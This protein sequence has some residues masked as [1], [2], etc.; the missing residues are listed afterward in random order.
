MFHR[1][2]IRW[3]LASLCAAGAFA[4][5]PAAT[6]AAGS[7]TLQWLA[8]AQR[9]A[10]LGHWRAPNELRFPLDRLFE[11]VGE[12][13]GSNEL[14]ARAAPPTTGQGVPV[15]KDVPVLSNLFRNGRAPE[16]R[17]VEAWLTTHLPRAIGGDVTVAF[18]ETR[19]R[20]YGAGGET[21]SVARELV[22]GAAEPLRAKAQRVLDEL[23]ALRG[24]QVMVELT[25]VTRPA[26]PDAR[27]L[28]KVEALE[29]RAWQLAL[30]GLREAA[31]SGASVNI[32]SS[33][34]VVT[35]QGQ[36]ASI[37]VGNDV[38]YVKGYAVEL[39]GEGSFVA[40]P[41]IGVAHEG[42][43]VEILPILF[44]AGDQVSLSL[45]VRLSNVTRPIATFEA[46]LGDG[47]LKAE[48]PEVATQSF[49]S[50]LVLAANGGGARIDGLVWTDPETRKPVRAEI[51]VAARVA[52]PPAPEAGAP[53]IF[54]PAGGSTENVVMLD[55]RDVDMLAGAKAGDAV[56][57]V[58]G[59]V[60]VGRWTVDHASGGFLVL[61]RIEGRAPVGAV[62]LRLAAK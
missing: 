18:E 38:S 33:P 1:R 2:L 5:E 8:L 19:T 51:Y 62:R 29:P 52:E 12:Q 13:R 9:N 26:P 53:K 15:L 35:G 30:A 58:D 16:L 4:Q 31:K 55:G 17:P 41:T 44:G 11:N 45:K 57:V 61:K 60:V 39:V 36:T 20:R 32:L 10:F 47:V 56:E 24:K 42:L 3:S 43:S 49:E 23:A 50:Q 48:R 6:D 59:D 25:L 22:L 14:A 7:A 37:S 40:D 54:L 27:P 34:R 46:K 21:T 28:E